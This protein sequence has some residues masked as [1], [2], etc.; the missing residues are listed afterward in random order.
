[1][2]ATKN[3]LFYG[4]NLDVLRKYIKAETIDLC[5][6]DPPFNS[7]RNYNQ[8]YNNIGKE[9]KAQAQAFVDTWTWD[10]E[11]IKG[12]EEI[13]TN[14]NGVFT[15]QSIQ[16][17]IGLKTVL[18]EGSL[19]AYLVSMTLRIAEI[20]RV[21]KPTGSF[22]FH[23]DPT[24]SHYLKLVLDAVFCANKGE[25][26]NEII[27][28]YRRWTGKAEKFQEL[29]D[30]IFF[31]TKTDKCVF[32]VQYTPYTEKSLKRKQN[33]H[34]R[35]K[36]DDV[37]VT[38]IDEN[39]VRDNDVWQI[40][41]LN[42]QS[43]ERLG[44]PT[45]KPEELLEKIIQASTN[46]GDTILDA[47]CGCGT[48]VAVAERLGRKWIGIDI[49][50]QSISLILKRITETFDE[51]TAAN[52]SLFGVPK[53]FESAVALAHKKDD[54][55]R[56][57]FEK[58]AVLT[59]SNNKAIINDKKG[60]DGGI[61]GTCFMVDR[62]NSGATIYPQ[63]LFSVKSDKKY[64]PSYIRDLNGVLERDKAAMGI[65]IVLH[66]ADNL[67]KESKKYG[68]YKNNLIDKTFPKI[69][70]VSVNDIMNGVLM[71]IPT[72]TS[73]LKEADSKAKDDTLKLF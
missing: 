42:S 11:A 3:Q 68:I 15:T 1:M 5:Y 50:Y 47:Y 62:D 56:K 35:V 57:E 65:I 52:V 10:D 2:A 33:Y 58:W 23:C 29:H 4:D 55:V 37:Y 25:F 54:R 38:H 45:Q 49:T 17:I 6:I 40:Q 60:G 30:V 7:K 24:A 16:L 32:N 36:G 39:G 73:R 64:P 69:Q 72:A 22:Y 18:G 21:L 53:D 12:F 59:Y 70:V 13:V 14:Y 67:I 20:H 28:H 44:Y 51:K 27:W 43:K 48:T 34:T 63:I 46:K 8:I 31:Y 9:D 41:L 66:D 19:I 26:R 61:D 71:D